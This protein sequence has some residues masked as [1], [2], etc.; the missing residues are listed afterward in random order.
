MGAFVR[1]CE[2]W[3]GTFTHHELVWEIQRYNHFPPNHPLFTLAGLGGELFAPLHIHKF[4]YLQLH[5]FKM[6]LLKSI[7]VQKLRKQ[8]SLRA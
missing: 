6:L 5:T 8:E 7:N 1:L 4:L 3:E 2:M